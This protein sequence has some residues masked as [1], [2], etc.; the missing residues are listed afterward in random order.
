MTDNHTLSEE[1]IDRNPFNQFEKWFGEHLLSGIPIPDSLSL[2]TSSRSGRVSVRT[3][4]LKDYSEKGFVFFT[5]YNS[6]KGTQLKSNPFAAML[7]YWP[8]SGRQVRIEGT[9]EKI[10]EEESMAY[11]RTR[12]VE[13]QLS[14]WAS[15]QSSIIPDRRHLEKRFLTYKFM[16]SEKSVEKPENWGGFLLIP[17]WFEF[18]QDGKFR[19]HDRISFTKKNDIWVINRLAP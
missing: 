14:A 5:N 17:E 13:S 9:T 7:F 10:S 19:L 18:W 4:L 6:R 16:F 3:V 1:T 12:P 11:F 15:E 8:E 2:A